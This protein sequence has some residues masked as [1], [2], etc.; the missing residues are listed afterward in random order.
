MAPTKKT[1]G[2]KAATS[3]PKKTAA[4]KKPPA[5]MSAK[6]TKPDFHTSSRVKVI[7]PKKVDPLA[8]VLVNIAANRDILTST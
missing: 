5:K 2:K 8:L 3:A 7:T 1:C 4:A 6:T